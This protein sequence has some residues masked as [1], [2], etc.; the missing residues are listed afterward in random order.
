MIRYANIED[1]DRIMDFIGLYW[2]KNHIMSRDRKLFEFQHLWGDKV[3]FVIAEENEQIN[4][5]LGFIPYSSD[6]CDIT[7]AIW[8]TLKTE[9]TMLGVRILQ[10][11]KAD[12][13]IKSISA[14]GINPKTR[15]VYQ[16]LG[17]YTG[18]MKHW[19]R[20]NDSIN[21]YHIAKV[22]YNRSEIG[23][24][25]LEARVVVTNLDDFVKA[26]NE[27]GVSSC[28]RVEG[29]LEKSLCFVKRRY[30]EH[31][32]YNYIKYG[33]E[34]DG[35]K[36]FVVFRIQHCCNK[37]VLRLID[38]LGDHFLIKYLMPQIDDWLKQ[39]NCEYIDCYETGVQDNYFVEGGWKEISETEDIIPE[40]FYPFEQRNIDIYYMSTLP[41][42]ILFKGD[43]DMDRPN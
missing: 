16:F 27:F 37:A 10:F 31:P 28:L 24:V 30:Y 19:Y 32:S 29:Q 20:L 1:I 38:C 42:V 17:H 8:K 2:R 22:N 9:D 7:L 23:N 41:D 43:G 15:G 3:S 25:S 11:L 40:Y 36:L 13:H 12:T 33:I 21:E 39:W 35:K 34:Q 18:K 4:G 5:I 26:Q 14:P 6:N